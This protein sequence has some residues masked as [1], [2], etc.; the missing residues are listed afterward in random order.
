MAQQMLASLIFVLISQATG[1]SP[2]TRGK[3]ALDTSAL[4]AEVRT[5][6]ALLRAQLK[7]VASLLYASY[8]L[9][10]ANTS[11]SLVR[12][13]CSK[14]LQFWPPFR[15][16]FTAQFQKPEGARSAPGPEAASGA[17][18]AAAPSTAR[19]DVVLE[20]RLDAI[21]DL[22]AHL[23]LAMNADVDVVRFGGAKY[24]G[25]AQRAAANVKHY[26]ASDQDGYGKRDNLACGIGCVRACAVAKKSSL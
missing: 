17:K 21:Q 20:R 16:K 26:I 1:T 11:A 13:A 4:P 5:T 3:G 25:A 6:V 8:D 15:L 24:R 22:T 18:G 12:S 14:F 19:K 23:C 10:H 7:A 2:S 9:V